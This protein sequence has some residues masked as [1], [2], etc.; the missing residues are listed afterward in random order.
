MAGTLKRERMLIPKLIH[1]IWVGAATFPSEFRRFRARWKTLYPDYDLIFWNNRRV[2]TLR[3]SA[4]EKAIL[5]HPRNPLSVQA[6]LLRYRILAEFGGIYVDTDTEPLRRLDC[7]EGL[8]F[9]AG[10]QRNGEIAVG[11]VGTVPSNP[12]LTEAYQR[13]L[14]SVD[15]YQDSEEIAQAHWVSG[16]GLFTQVYWPKYAR[17]RHFKIFQEKCFYPYWCDEKH[18]RHEDFGRTCPEAYSVHHWAHSWN[19]ERQPAGT[20]SDLPDRAG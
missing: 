5:F 4:R 14:E 16:P 13:A 2:G 12:L 19:A 6:D 10:F 1:H 3:M 8:E 11:I 15:Y 17:K 9:F 20:K 7:L 18:R